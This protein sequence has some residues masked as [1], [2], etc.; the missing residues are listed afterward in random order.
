[1]RRWPLAAAG[2]LLAASLAGCGS[3]DQAEL[4][5]PTVPAATSATSATES[6]SS[7]SATKRNEPDCSDEALQASPGFENFEMHGQCW[8]GFA[9]PGVP[10]SDHI[11]LAQWDG[12]HWVEVEPDGVWDGMGMHRPCYNPGRLEELGVPE[13]LAKKEPRCGV[14]PPG[15]EPPHKKQTKASTPVP[16]SSTLDPNWGIKRDSDGMIVEAQ[17]EGVKRQISAPNCDGR[18]ILILDSV[19][20]DG[21]IGSTHSKLAFDIAYLGDGNA[22][23][24]YPG[25]CPSLRAQVDG[26]D[27][28]PVYL[29]FGHDTDALCAAKKDYGGNARVLSDREEYLD[30]C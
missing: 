30:P 9:R 6:S 18:G 4:A 21:D 16:T 11:V 19:I 15:Q 13:N 12:K 7:T 3:S 28:Y 26:N 24:T 1:M 14:Y 29:D 17:F 22:E 10:Q 2:V 25:H 8:S 23:F 5:E 20:A 27:I